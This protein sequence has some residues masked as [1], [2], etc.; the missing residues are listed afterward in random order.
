MY[1]LTEV[2]VDCMENPSCT[3][4]VFSTLE[5]AKAATMHAIFVMHAERGSQTVAFEWKE[6]GGGNHYVDCVPTLGH[7][8]VISEIK[9]DDYDFSRQPDLD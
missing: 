2:F 8:W 7:E 3:L 5:K 6:D 9:V 4:G 1:M